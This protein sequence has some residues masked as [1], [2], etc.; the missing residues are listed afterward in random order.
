MFMMY[1][2]VVGGGELGIRNGEWGERNGSVDGS[3]D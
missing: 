3:M 2:Q 1:I